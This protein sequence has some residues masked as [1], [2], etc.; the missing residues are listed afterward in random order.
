ML[1]HPSG[2]EGSQAINGKGMGY[3]SPALEVIHSRP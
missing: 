3:L 2:A 1:F